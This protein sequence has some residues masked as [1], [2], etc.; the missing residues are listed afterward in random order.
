MRGLYIA[1]EQNSSLCVSAVVVTLGGDDIEDCVPDREQVDN[2]RGKVEVGDKQERDKQRS[3]N[4]RTLVTSW[5][6]CK[7]TLSHNVV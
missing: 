2:E 3:Y 7:D 5:M 4:K 1:T 6:A